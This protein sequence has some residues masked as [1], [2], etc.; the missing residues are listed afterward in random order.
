VRCRLILHPRMEGR[1]DMAVD[2]ALAEAVGEGQSPAV[3]RLYGFSP[4][5][6]SL[7]R[8]QPAR[9]LCV[10][11]AF[12]ADG[13]TLVRRPTGGH[14]VLHDAE[15]T[16]AVIVSKAGAEAA[17]GSSRK[18]AVYRFIA[19]IL[20]AG[21]AN[22]GVAGVVN[23]A[24]KG[25][26]HNPD[27]FGSAGEFEIASR[28]GHKLIGSAQ[29]TTRLAVLQHGSIPWENPGNRIF[30]YLRAEQPLDSH[31]PS[32]L[33]EETGTRHTFEMVRGAFAA[34]FR[35]ALDAEDS[36]LTAEEEA[37]AQAILRDKYARDE[38][39]LAH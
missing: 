27:C 7:G 11:E 17:L 3:V 24:Q 9:G 35:A 14:A 4:P 20:V 16:Y 39:N 8:F 30:R 33:D 6:L 25:D 31:P 38:W 19:D 5:T 23:A 21:L 12:A 2:E 29:M 36:A 18:R 32:C 28:A 1:L 15:L 10:A 34:A 13:V 37:A 22:L 26:A